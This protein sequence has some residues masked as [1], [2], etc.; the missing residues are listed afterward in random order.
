MS[1]TRNTI[2]K[3]IVLNTVNRLRNHPTAENIYEEIVKEHPTISKAT[4]YR[5]LNQMAEQGVVLRIPFPNAAD[6]YDF[7]NTNHYHLKCSTCGQVFDVQIPYIAALN[8][9]KMEGSNFLFEDHHLV[10]KGKCPDCNIG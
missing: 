9:V 4:V 3:D 5:N 7:N 6:R 1:K 2:Q 8:D 10:F